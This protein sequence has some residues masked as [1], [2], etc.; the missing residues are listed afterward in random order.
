MSAWSR[1][2]R[3]L[4]ACGLVLLAL[5]SV[6]RADAASGGP[7]K[8][9]ADAQTAFRFDI[10]S[11]S[12]DGVLAAFERTTSIS[13]T[14]PASLRGTVQTLHSPG[15][16]GTY[17]AERALERLLAGTGLTHHLAGTN[18]Y[19]LEV[20]H[21]SEN[22]EVRASVSD[23][24]A[25]S[26]TATKTLTPLRDVPQSVTVVTRAM[27]EDQAMQSMADVVRYVPG[28]G[29]GQ[30]EGN[31]D[32]PILRGNSTTADFFVDGVRDDVQYFRDL[33]NVDRVEA[34]KGPNAMIF[35]RGGAGGV[36]NR[37]TRY[38]DWNTAHE[39]TLQGGS[40]AHRRAS[41]D[42]DRPLGRSVAARLTGMYENSESYRSG[43]GIERYG[44]NPTF[45]YS[46]RHSTTLR[47]GYERFHDERTADRGIPSRGDRPVETD[48]STFFGDPDRSAASVTV[49][50][51]TAVVDHKFAGNAMLRN[52]TRFADYDKF[53][54]NVYPGSAVSADGTM[55]SL[56]AYNN[57]TGRQNF[58]NQT[59]VNLTAFTGRFKHVLLAG[60]EFGRQ[61]TDNRR[62]TGYFTAIGPNVTSFAVPVSA[63]TVSVPMSFRQSATDADNHGVA[64]VAA[65]YG[66]D[67]VQLSR[68]VQAVVG[69][70]FD[71]FDVDFHNNRT[72][73]DFSST[74]NLISPRVGLIFKPVE[75]VSI[76]TSYSLTY[77]PRA[78]EQLS[79]LSLTNQSLDP[80]KFT[81]YEVGA[82]WDPR[83]ALSVTA[84]VYR[85]NR[86]NVVVPDPNDASRSILVDG[87][88][89]NGFELGLTGR[90]T[91]AWSAAG[92]YA[93]QD[94]QITSTLSA[95]AR[96][97][98][99]LAQ[100]PAHTFSLWNR[101]D[102]T[103]RWGLGVG[104]IH[105]GDMFTSTDN[106]VLLP[107]FTRVDGA[108]FVN[109]TRAL[110]AQVNIENLLDE[111]YYAFANGNNNIT[112]G[113]PRAFRVTLITR[114]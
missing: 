58:F 1:R 114:F 95:S 69:L 37:A 7:S 91:R 90:I 24:A 112:P 64:T 81:N 60:A 49:N 111:K 52:R 79:S 62:E 20:R 88:R 86:T 71:R 107:S 6:T 17:T 16:S 42:L 38:A 92:G 43:V 31:R 94:G 70:R 41:F 110:A 101:Y 54:Q 47:V 89:T 93:Y 103:E 27:I 113:S 35:G 55:A 12:L 32:T 68:Y 77:V 40:D 96:A 102:V 36:I 34:L 78:G 98:A 53:Y 97:G 106:T 63:P 84:A 104:I 46:L 80:E 85:L 21:V 11:G 39:I 5:T 75:P 10:P 99:K 108:L 8:D 18:T 48:R 59:D 51:L 13:V 61:D 2:T 67:Q 15:V 33:Y 30:G 28:V 26:L 74:D 19:A 66:Q 83:P 100:V 73:A 105:N 4:P 57:A 65:L 82:K 45:A 72:S 9:R 87:Q 25:G 3:L 22:V 109:L 56:S 76:Y 29:M 23:I 44:F 50:A 14:V